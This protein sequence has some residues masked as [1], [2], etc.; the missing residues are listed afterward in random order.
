MI[1]TNLISLP[2]DKMHK[3]PAEQNQ[4]LKSNYLILIHIPV[5][6]WKMDISCE[7][8]EMCRSGRQNNVYHMG[9]DEISIV[10][11]KIHSTCLFKPDEMLYTAYIREIMRIGE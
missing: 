3:V 1:Y 9:Y 7:K 2:M 10:T 8:L 6:L 11:K 4:C 5:M